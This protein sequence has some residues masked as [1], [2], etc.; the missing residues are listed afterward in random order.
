MSCALGCFGTPLLFHPTATTLLAASAPLTTNTLTRRNA[1]L[2]AL[3]QQDANDITAANYPSIGSWSGPRPGTFLNGS[4][5]VRARDQRIVAAW[6]IDM[7]IVLLPVITSAVTAAKGY[8]SVGAGIFIGMVVWLL[9]PWAYGFCCLGGNTLG[10][11]LAG[12]KLVKLSDGFNPG[13]W[14]N[15]G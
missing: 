9:F 6:A 13:F 3:P 8:G 11:L 4:W 15:G 10:T 7:G 1:A 5:G 2:A 14:R 12:T